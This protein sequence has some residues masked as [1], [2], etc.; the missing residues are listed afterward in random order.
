VCIGIGSDYAERCVASNARLLPSGSV[1]PAD[2]GIRTENGDVTSIQNEV[3]TGR[4]LPVRNNYIIVITL[5]VNGT[6]VRSDGFQL[7]KMFVDLIGVGT[8]SSTDKMEV[9]TILKEALV[10]VDRRVGGVDLVRC[11]LE[12]K[13]SVKR[14]ASYVADMT[15]EAMNSSAMT[16]AFSVAVGLVGLLASLF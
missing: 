11:E 13:L 3:A 1:C 2:D 4:D 12:E 9:C 15:F 16:V 7:V 14:D 8:P 6:T 5:V 10:K